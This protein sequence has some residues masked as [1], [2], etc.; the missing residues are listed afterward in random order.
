MPDRIRRPLPVPPVISMPR[1]SFSP[2]AAQKALAT[3]SDLFA[4]LPADVVDAFLGR[5]TPRRFVPKELLFVEGEALGG[6]YLLVGVQVKLTKLNAAGREVIVSIAGAG[7]PLAAVA[8][9]PGPGTYPVS[10]QAL[11]LCHAFFW[12]REEAGSLVAEAPLLHR[13][14]L[15]VTS[16]RT[17]HVMESL[18]DVA[19]ERVPSRLAGA[20]LRLARR[21]GRPTGDAIELPFPLTHQELA[22]MIGATLFTVSRQLSEWSDRGLS[23]G[24]RSECGSS[25]RTASPRSRGSTGP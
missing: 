20:L 24:G 13:N 18:R 25:V 16:S 23:P 19:T 4:D 6:L 2:S 5:A 17:L 12:I 3:G 15:Q 8:A 11:T 10:G 22:E 14:L 21:E 1:E 7:E 9:L